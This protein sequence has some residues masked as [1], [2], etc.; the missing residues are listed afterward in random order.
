MAD[1]LDIGALNSLPQPFLARFVGGDVWPIYDICVET[2]LTRIDVC[3]KLDIKDFCEITHLTDC[4][5]QTHET[6]QF[7]LDNNVARE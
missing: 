7:W 6:E 3:G 1:K 4:D 5:G 2:G